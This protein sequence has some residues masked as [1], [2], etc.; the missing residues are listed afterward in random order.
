MAALVPRCASASCQRGARDVS[1]VTEVICNAGGGAR[2]GPVHPRAHRRAVIAAISTSPQRAFGVDWTLVQPGATARATLG[3]ALPLVL[4]CVTSHLDWAVFAALGALSAGFA[5]FRGESRTRVA[6]VLLA[7]AGMAISTMVG[8]SLAATWPWLLVPAVGLWGYLTGL[9]VSLG[10]APAVAIMQWPVA[11]LISVGLP[12]SPRDALFRGALVFLGGALQ[13]ALVALSWT[14]AAGRRERA[15]L[16]A[17][18]RGLAAYARRIAQ[19]AAGAPDPA[20]FEARA[21]LSDANPLLPESERMADLD[22]LAEAERIRTSLAALAGGASDADTGDALRA[23][24]NDS[25]TVL[26]L[27][28]CALRSIDGQAG[29]SALLAQRLASVRVP[30]SAPWRWGAET[31]LAQMREV[32][33]IAGGAPRLARAF[34]LEPARPS[35]MWSVLRAAL[36]SLRANAGL[37]SEAGRHALRLAVIAAIAEAV[38]EVTHLPQGRWLTMTVF[39]VLRPDYRSTLSRAFGRAAGT[40]LGAC[41]GAAVV[42]AVHPNDPGVVVAACIAAAAAFALFDVNYTLFSLPVTVLVVML[43]MLIGIP[44]VP[45]AEARVLDTLLGAAVALLAFRVWATWHST[46]AANQFATLVQAHCAYA[47]ALLREMCAPRAGNRQLMALQADARRARSDAQAAIERLADERPDGRFTPTFA[48]S[49]L[50]TVSRLAHAELALHALMNANHASCTPGV[51][52]MAAEL[53]RV[54]GDAAERLRGEPGDARP[55]RLR[56]L[57]AS[58]LATMPPDEALASITDRLVDAANSLHDLVLS[59]ARAA[60]AEAPAHPRASGVA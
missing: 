23:F 1:P 52:D 19:G 28:A 47:A 34:E 13:A 3:V 14:V 51:G 42:L 54:L 12:L 48:A 43:L 29:L 9:S 40:M 20:P 25:A 7:G 26:D 53:A 41:V 21:I 33:R 4:G 2:H 36:A 27:L 45:T 17:A 50:A 32:A 16:A 11:L 49:L 31:L 24:A 30:V 55:S 56:A 15:S 22:L 58:L 60:P 44:A 46:S 8:A 39:L 5:S 6:A 57:H 38:V 10:P 59:H 35:G 18:Y 37:K